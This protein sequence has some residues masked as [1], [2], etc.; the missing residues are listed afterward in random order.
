MEVTIDLDKHL[1][2]Q[3][4]RMQVW[5]HIERSP[6]WCESNYQRIFYAC[7]LNQNEAL[8]DVI[9]KIQST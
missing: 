3:N 6:R 4:S 1:M 5:C 8:F 2:P 7:Q 9:R